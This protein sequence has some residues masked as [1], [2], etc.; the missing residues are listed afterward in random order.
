M[1]RSN[2]M[3]KI[4]I[5]F[6]VLLQL[7]AFQSSTSPENWIDFP[8]NEKFKLE[9]K[10]VK[11]L[12][13]KGLPKSALKMV[14]QIYDEAKRT[15]N[16]EQV[17]KAIVYRSKFVSQT[18]EDAI[19]GIINQIKEEVA[20]SKF[21]LKQILHS[22]LASY[23][24]AYY[25]ERQWIINQRTVIPGLQS[26][27][28]SNWD[29]MDFL[30]NM[31]EHLKYSLE[32]SDSLQQVKIDVFGDI[33]N[34]GTQPG[35][36]R[37]GL[38]DF[39][40]HR[41]I[42]Y[43]NISKH[44]NPLL[45]DDQF[46]SNTSYFSEA[47]DFIKLTLQSDDGSSNHYLILKIYQDILGYRMKQDNSPA[48]I[49]ADL[50]RINYLYTNSTSDNKDGL[51]LK[52]L[53]HLKKKYAENAHVGEIIY[54]EAEYYL[55]KSHNFNSLDSLSNQFVDY[56]KKAESLYLLVIEKYPESQVA[57]KCQHSL[58]LLKKKELS[59]ELEKGI[60]PEKAFPCRIEFK[61][62]TK[63]Y[64]RYLK[65]D[66]SDYFN[67]YVT[68]RGRNGFEKLINKSEIVKERKIETEG[69]DD[70]NAHSI[71]SVEE[72]LPIGKYIFIITNNK[73]FN[74]SHGLYAWSFIDVSNIAYINRSNRYKGENELV[75]I[76]RKKG[77]PLSNVK[78]DRLSVQYSR[79]IQRNEI[80]K[81]GSIQSVKGGFVEL[82]STGRQ[83]RHNYIL[84][85]KKGDDYLI[86]NDN[87]HNPGRHEEQ[88]RTQCSFFSDR[89]IY[90]PG[91][92]VYFKGILHS[93]KG[94]TS[95]VVAGKKTK[96]QLIDANWQTVK[97]FDFMSN[98]F[99]SF[100][101]SFTLPNSALTGSFRIKNEYGT[102]EFR[103]E[104]Y[105]R[106]KIKVEFLPIEGQYRFNDY[107]IVKGTV[108]S[109]TGHPVSL[110]D[111]KYTVN[112][113]SFRPFNS[114][115]MPWQA[116]RQI[117]YGKVKTNENGEFEIV[118]KAISPN[119][120]MPNANLNFSV[121]ID[122]TDQNG[123]TQ[124]AS[125]V[126]PIRAEAIT[127]SSNF[128][129]TI[130]L[131]TETANEFDLIVKTIQGQE[132]NDVVNVEVFQLETPR[133]LYE[134]KLRRAEINLK[135]KDQWQE[136]LPQMEYNEELK[137]ENFLVKKQVAI[138]NIDTEKNKSISVS[139]FGNRTP[140]YY[141][142]RF[143]TKD[144][145]DRTVERVIYS[146]F[147]DSS[148]KKLHTP[149][150][151][152]FVSLTN[153]VEPGESAKILIGTGIDKVDV[154]YEILDQDK[155]LTQEWISLKKGQRIIEIP[156]EEKH[157]GGIYVSFTFASNNHIFKYL[158]KVDV[159][160]SNKKL[161]ITFET[162]RDKL[163]P[164]EKEEW[165][166]KIKGAMGDKLAAELLCGMYDAS[167]DKFAAN[168]WWSF[169]RIPY[170]HLSPF[171][172]TTFNSGHGQFFNKDY[173]HPIRPADLYY[174][175]LLWFGV[176]GYYMDGLFAVESSGGMDVLRSRRNKGFEG[177]ELMF[178]P[179]TFDMDASA[180][181][182]M[183]DNNLPN[184]AQEVPPMPGQSSSTKDV[185][186]AVVHTRTNFNE[187]AFFY[188]HLQTDNEGNV[189]V[190]FHVPE[191][192]TQWNIN[193]IAHSKDLSIGLF[194]KELI[195]KKELMAEANPPRFF[196]EGDRIVFPVKISNMTEEAQTG[197]VMLEFVDALTYEKITLSKEDEKKSF[198]VAENGNLT[199]AWELM[200]PENV[201]AVTYTV[202]ASTG[203]FS[204]G[205]SKTLPVLSNRMLVT[206]SLP[207]SVRKAGNTSFEFSKLKV[208]KSSTL[209]HH[210][211]TLEFTQNPAWYAV[212]AL[213]FL[214]EFPHECAEQLFSR[215]YANCLAEHIVNSLPEI[216]RVFNQWKISD[217][218]ETFLSN[219]EKNEELK[220][221][222]L[223]ETPW[224]RDAM[225]EKQQKENI[226][227]LFDL[228][229]MQDE[230][231][232]AWHKLEKMQ[233]ENGAWPWFPGLYENRYITQ[234][235]V[236]GMGHLKQLGVI[237]I[238]HNPSQYEVIRQA[239][240][241]LDK[242]MHKDFTRLEIKKELSS[243][244]VH[245]LYTRS[246]FQDII[247]HD[248]YEIAYQ[249][250]ISKAKKD[251]LK[252]NK[253]EQAMI[254]LALYRHEDQKTP[255]DII[256]SLK[257]F[258]ISSDEFGMYWKSGNG[259]Y[260]NQ[261]PIEQQAL[262][263]ELF[264][265]VAK[266]QHMVNELKIW[267]LKQKQ[268]QAWKTTKATADAVYSLLISGDNWL[269]SKE[270]LSVKVGNTLIDPAK[271]EDI[272]LE[273]GT[274]YFKK[275][276]DNGEIVP[277][278]GNITVTKSADRLSWGAL[279]WQYFE[280]LD[281]ITSHNT[282]IF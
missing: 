108:K 221:L 74:L 3:V 192:L 90:R 86:S 76:D 171:S 227:L 103:V 170:L 94:N 66:S 217:N 44:V 182:K 93:G 196:R 89:K 225:N 83:Y 11:E 150:T 177:D 239:I 209:K 124:S 80:V 259:W 186:V 42:Q 17:A 223:N 214:M 193:G 194:K 20:V 100:S 96:V 143:T 81:T 128:P 234:H 28:I 255:Q 142:I 203:T 144:K 159:P 114:Y 85:F 9:W 115:F 281:K 40:A 2:K 246:F 185:D 139:Q 257:E 261:A 210:R 248:T 78:I 23:F 231:A 264:E 47:K 258:I 191:S 109:Y 253:Y 5:G 49:D 146:E 152:W 56:A 12:E 205:E 251:W 84:V 232:L 180:I 202:K 178:M 136:S 195:T 252:F 106:P 155:K 220:N 149:K 181:E 52:L 263:I 60:I 179:E 279:Y 51:Y 87:F 245:Y 32:N 131:S 199:V 27:D 269:D 22:Y 212:Q 278:M 134:N 240:A 138:F 197:E 176:G 8:E 219:L 145:F 237:D 7:L 244:L 250:Y 268:T 39:L 132:L 184:E 282:G 110:A 168:P 68:N 147:F 201:H 61:N 242:E 123:E 140:G 207:M 65:V 37:P 163:V 121:D 167:L 235:I 274:G 97:E 50:L 19:P 169:F 116:N 104:E 135:S 82:P 36:I 151:N 77:N 154:L 16:Q 198:S 164:G 45:S 95:Q 4:L 189:I 183:E 256:N 48:L 63:I 148:S 71:M 158:R 21:P 175:Q 55:E 162:F 260:W 126:I 122:A 15:N 241:Y 53:G 277:E 33:I 70:L 206:E 102:H 46:L 280:D 161:D 58:E 120:E 236:A 105:K 215:Y 88:D 224:V 57:K 187:T 156:I 38:Y 6:F 216:K 204:D 1:I 276:W 91:Q 99:G 271:D 98:E 125:I 26:E 64:G 14:N 29:K 247:M 73:K 129:S 130:D 273:A 43:H 229:K 34:E 59:L 254:A 112:R 166:L 75:V 92:I 35:G 107:I 153:S 222:I 54:R 275:S 79:G 25:S 160:F 157:R 272:A 72:G 137:P 24:W 267:L 117:D 174:D 190:S 101:G 13:K 249:H 228:N 133:L 67:H 41:A 213:P 119:I 262:M 226:A 18:E 31:Q 30:T 111:V 200:I 208:T 233:M 265:E 218:K 10:K 173:R 238:K 62:I 266:D 188:P 243:L 211:L 141:K 172:S 165:R 118:F 127:I 270:K 113:S 230:L 69:Q